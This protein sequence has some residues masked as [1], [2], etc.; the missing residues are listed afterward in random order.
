M[1]WG[2][3]KDWPLGEIPAGYLGWCLEEVRN[4]DATLRRA[5]QHELAER[6]GCRPTPPRPTLALPDP[7]VRDA[8]HALIGAGYRTAAKRMHP[9]AGG[10]HA[11]MIYLGAARDWLTRI[12]ED[13]A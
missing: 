4:L 10:D 7:A 9:D 2:K 5:I 8:A 3:H 6:I 13:A 11:S 1:P 12:L